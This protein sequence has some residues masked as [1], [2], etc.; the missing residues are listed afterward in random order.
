MKQKL[1]FTLILAISF[2]ACEPV[3]QSVGFTNWSDDGSEYKFFLGTESSIDVVMAFD[4]AA[5]AKTYDNFREIFVDSA[6]FTYQNGVTHTLDQFIAMNQNRD[7]LLLAN[8]ATL[9]WT[10]QNAFSVDIDPKR[11]GEHVNMMYK[12]EYI[13]DDEKSQFYANLWFYVVDGKI[14][15]VNQYNQNV[16]QEQ[17]S[18]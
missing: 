5:Q 18:E 13:D 2:T 9:K 17:D 15:M 6:I 16:L 7:S 8:E 14:V 3:K 4:A 11:G 12:G 10:P 1:F